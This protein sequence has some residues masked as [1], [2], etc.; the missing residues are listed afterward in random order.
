MPVHKPKKQEREKSMLKNILS[1]SHQILRESLKEGDTAVDA[2]AGRGNDTLFLSEIVGDTGKVLAFDIQTEAI[3][4]TRSL[5][6]N[7]KR[8]NVQLFH[9]DH[10]LMDEI[11]AGSGSE[12]IGGAIFNLGYLPGSRK[13]LITKPESTL[14]ALSALLSRLKTNGIIV[15]VVYHGHPGGEAEKEALLDFCQKLDQKFF[16]VLHYNF[17]NQRNNPPFILA[18]EKREGV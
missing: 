12:Q 10:S 17:I 15:L 6:S 4:T 9:C 3:Q 16:H 18:I 14:P 7:E 2:T 11:I 8:T 13:D 5:L 1:F